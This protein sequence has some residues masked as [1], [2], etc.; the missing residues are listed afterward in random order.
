MKIRRAHA[1]LLGVVGIAASTNCSSESAGAGDKAPG[2]TDL[3]VTWTFS[4]K[5]ASAEECTTRGGTK[6]YVNLSGTYDPSLHQSVTEECAT[7]SV[8]FANLNLDKLGMP[9]LEGALINAKEIRVTQTGLTVT[10]TSGPTNVTLDF[11][12]V[13]DGGAG[14]ASSSSSSSSKAASSSASSSSASSSSSSAS[15]SASGGTDAG[16]DGG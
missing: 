9:Y 15:S 10:P 2:P 14:G 1:L 7:G 5:P 12:P 13:P 11:F 6:V 4:G 8:K 16:A 3:T